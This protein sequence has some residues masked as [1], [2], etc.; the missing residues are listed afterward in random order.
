MI[1]EHAQDSIVQAILES[2]D[3][4]DVENFLCEGNAHCDDE[5]ND[6][7]LIEQ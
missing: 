6:K 7:N 1:V 4:E 3:Y 2:S 5:F